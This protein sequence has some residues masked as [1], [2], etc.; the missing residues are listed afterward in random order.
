LGGNRGRDAAPGELSY[1][2]AVRFGRS[3]VAAAIVAA[4]VVAVSCSDSGSDGPPTCSYGGMTYSVGQSFFCGAGTFTCQA[5]GLFDNDF[6]ESC[7]P[8][9]DDGSLPDAYVDARYADVSSDWSMLDAPTDD[10]DANA[11]DAPSDTPIEAPSDAVSDA[12]DD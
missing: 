7:E 8:E 12:A 10:G 2:E 5:N 3:I 6:D 4:S 11:T 9:D 1:G